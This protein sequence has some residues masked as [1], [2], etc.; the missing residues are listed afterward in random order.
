MT[1]KIPFGVCLVLAQQRFRQNKGLVLMVLTFFVATAIV[2]FLHG[3][4]PGFLV[5]K[6]RGLRDYQKHSR[7]ILISQSP[8]LPI[9]VP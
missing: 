1:L 6:I 4:V 9:S 3:L 7:S 5:S 8:N 2:S